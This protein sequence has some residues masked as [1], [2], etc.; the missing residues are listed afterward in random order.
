MILKLLIE[1]QKMNIFLPL[2]KDV[3]LELSYSNSLEKIMLYNNRKKKK[4]LSSENK[5]DEIANC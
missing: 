5:Q 1:K 4:V 3:Y 2:N